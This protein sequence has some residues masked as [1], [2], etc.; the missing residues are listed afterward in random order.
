[1]RKLFVLSLVVLGLALTTNSAFA[2]RRKV[3]EFANRRQHEKWQQQV[4][5][6]Q[7]R[8]KQRVV[9]TFTIPQPNYGYPGYGYG[10]GGYGGGIGNGGYQYVLVPGGYQV[11][12]GVVQYVPAH[13]VMVPSY[14][15]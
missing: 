15:W 11:I 13:Y 4:R 12:N 8:A 9:P 14:G 10:N 5:K 6:E 7:A 2:Q 3:D 1:M